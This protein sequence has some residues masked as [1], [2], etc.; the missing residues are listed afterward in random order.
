[1]LLERGT[2]VDLFAAVALGDVQHVQD[3][4]R[5]NP[6]LVNIHRADVMTPLHMAA[7]IKATDPEQIE[8]VEIILSQGAPVN[9]RNKKDQTPLDLAIVGDNT[10]LTDSLRRYGA[11]LAEE[12]D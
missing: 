11:R 7:S 9:I 8:C 4:L 6:E 3:L 5:E 10:V 12:E 1:M 2:K